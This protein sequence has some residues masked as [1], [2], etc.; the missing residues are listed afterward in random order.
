MIFWLF[1]CL[2]LIIANDQNLPDLDIIKKLIK[3]KQ[4]KVDTSKIKIESNKGI[5]LN[6]I[7]LFNR[8]KYIFKNN[9]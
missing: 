3:K 9:F 1:L 8:K 5:N 7:S 2:G 6:F 4:S